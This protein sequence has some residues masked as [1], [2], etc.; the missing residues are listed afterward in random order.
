MDPRRFPVSLDV[1]DTLTVSGYQFGQVQDGDHYVELGGSKI[2][3]YDKW[4][5][6]PGTSDVTIQF[7]VPE[8]ANTNWFFAKDLDLAVV[9]HGHKSNVKS[10]EVDP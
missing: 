3:S 9:N 6:A 2:A 7:K 8:A 1:G 5:Q 10:I 4:E